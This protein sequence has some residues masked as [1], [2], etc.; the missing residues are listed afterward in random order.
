[1]RMPLDCFLPRGPW[2]PLPSPGSWPAG[3]EERRGE[4]EMREGP[5]LALPVREVP[6]GALLRAPEAAP[7][8]AAPA[9]DSPEWDGAWALPDAWDALPVW[10]A[11]VRLSFRPWLEPAEP[12]LRA[13]E[14]PEPSGRRMLRCSLESMRTASF[15]E[16]SLDVLWRKPPAV[17][18]FAQTKTDG[19][20]PPC[21]YYT[22][23]HPAK[24]SEIPLKI[25]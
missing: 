2:E 9:W 23:T 16:N 24:Y 8:R 18:V 1:M 6:R 3:R 12:A 10:A 14:V 22:T 20:G 11:P 5:F 21:W 4:E 17:R 19:R 7:L 15:A 25:V 13:P